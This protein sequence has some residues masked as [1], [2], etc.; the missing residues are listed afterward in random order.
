MRV[1]ESEIKQIN[2]LYLQYGTYAA[3]A[4]EVGRAPSTVKKYIDPNYQSTIPKVKEDKEIDFTSLIITK[5]LDIF[6]LEW[7]KGHSHESVLY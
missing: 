3:V 4:R 6:S 2:E 7:E 1:T 5:A